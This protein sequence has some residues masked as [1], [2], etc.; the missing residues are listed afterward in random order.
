MGGKPLKHLGSRAHKQRQAEPCP[1]LRV[2]WSAWPCRCGCTGLS[3]Q[4]EAVVERMAAYLQQG[5][6]RRVLAAWKAYV[7][8]RVGSR[9][10]ET[11]ASW[12][13]H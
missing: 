6:A 9:E 4:R 11:T 13:P 2:L 7:A 8:E 10:I 3:G 1:R 12:R 5:G